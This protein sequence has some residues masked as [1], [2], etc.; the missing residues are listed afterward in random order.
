[1]KLTREQVR[2]LRL[3]LGCGTLASFR[4]TWSAMPAQRRSEILGEV[5]P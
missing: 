1:M 2:E 5:F 4:A 3:V